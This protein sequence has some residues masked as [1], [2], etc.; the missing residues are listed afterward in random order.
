MKVVVTGGSGFIG[1]HLIDGLLAQGHSVTNI[2]RVPPKH[3]DVQ[4]DY[5]DITDLH[6]LLQ[7]MP[8]T[9]MVF[10]L[11]AMSNVNEIYKYPKYSVRANVEGTVN[12][13]EAARM[14]NVKR[15]LFASTIWVYDAAEGSGP[16]NEDTAFSLPQ[17]GHIYTATKIACE[18]LIHSWNSLYGLPFTIMR[19]GIPFG[20]RMRENLVTP[21]FIK[22]ALTG[23]PITI[24]GS[25]EQYRKFVY[26]DDL[27]EAQLLCTDDHAENQV[28]NFE[29]NKKIAIKQIA[30]TLQDIIPS[31][32]IKYAP[33]RPGDFKG[34]EISNAK[35]KD[36]LNWEPRTDY[37]VGLGKT[38]E[39]FRE[40]WGL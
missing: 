6:S 34:K 18:N 37:E 14:C 32:T 40:K 26:I 7:V 24:Q 12:I 2:D 25:G 11:A 5:I 38:I 20:P 17:T 22:K 23:E 9:D 21:I 13:L 35:A 8:D 36:I 30:E 27:T 1:S 19:Y 31:T 28:F 10:H 16:F 15:V 3:S 39:W 4:T 33:A 29:G